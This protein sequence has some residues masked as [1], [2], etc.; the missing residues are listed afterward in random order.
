M[1]GAQQTITSELTSITGSAGQAGG[2]SFVSGFSGKLGALKGVMSKVLPVASVALIGKALFDVG[3]EFDEMTDTIVTGTG[4]SGQALEDLKDAAEGIATTVPVSFADAGDIVQDLNTRLGLTGDT[5]QEVGTQVAQ[6]GELTGEAFDTEGF[7]GA[8][9]AW[10]ISAEDMSGKLDELFAISQSTGIGINDLVGITE[11]AAPQMQALGYSYDETAAM[12]GLLDKAGL[13]ANST[14]T[15]MS[16]AL[17]T[18][19]KDG[20]DPTEALQRVTEE[21][22]G[23]IESGD[24]AAALDLASQIFGTKGAPEFVK[25][26]QDGTLN[27]AD[28]TAAMQNSSGIIGE[29]SEKTMSFS[30]H[31]Q[32]LK[33]Q[34]KEM[35]EPIG[36]AVFQGLS[37]VMEKIST[38][39]GKFAD[40]PGKKI[41]DVFSR[42]F[43]WGKRVVE[44]FGNSLKKATGLKSFSDGAGKAK[45][46]VK[47]L[48]NAVKP[49]FNILSRILKTVIPPLARI[50]GTV[51]GTA[52][53]VVG[54]V[55]GTVINVIAKLIGK[56]TSVAGK[57]GSFFGSIKEKAGSFREKISSVFS[58]VKAKI[59]NIK[60]AFSSMKE[61]INEKI[62]SI[63]E[64]FQGFKDKITA[65]FSFLS[66]IKLP[67]FNVS[68]K[69]PYGIGGKG[70]KP[71]F[72]I[73]WYAKGAILDKPTI[74]G[75]GESGREGVIP[76][77][78][79]AMR[80]FAQAI[81]EQ[82]GGDSNGIV[83]NL[84]Y[85]A[86]ADAQ[87]MV[88]D[89]ARGLKRYRMAGVF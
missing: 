75:A 53:R 4:A 5:L 62:E 74:F 88:S 11:K 9:S 30:E 67:H 83:I 31:A 76:L 23:Y 8:M 33:N 78:G 87:E 66:N 52:F 1:Q 39:F 77:E 20:E 84:N 3:S 47:T 46:A 44:I 16:K 73:E 45:N 41:A 40:G 15:K 81:A 34:F 82:M 26:V 58:A 79:E 35:L 55:I 29:T 24:E 19:A 12:A 10:G 89:I 38:A 86:G 80:P 18:L 2:A 42:V 63:K 36:S 57:F 22:G 68:G 49:L 70:E 14:M 54:K 50:L 56:I 59:H 69:F 32:V 37:T 17:T 6:V 64:K 28:F 27:V 60:E 48:F 21:I 25:A 7:S 65:P 43:N 13:D 71:S 85:D 61:S 51:L 72:S